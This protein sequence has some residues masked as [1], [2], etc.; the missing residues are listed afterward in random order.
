M[1]AQGIGLKVASAM[2]GR[3]AVTTSVCSEMLLMPT[4][5]DEVPD[6]DLIGLQ[7]INDMLLAIGLPGGELSIIFV[8]TNSQVFIVKNEDLAFVGYSPQANYVIY[9]K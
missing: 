2:L 5:I 9:S 8:L 6:L 3:M 7:A 4:V 1:V